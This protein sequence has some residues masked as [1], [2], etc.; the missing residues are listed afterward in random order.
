M[1]AAV[2]ADILSQK[3]DSCTTYSTQQ[4]VTC[5]SSE[6]QGGWTQVYNQFGF[7]D[8]T[9]DASCNPAFG[10]GNTFLP[11]ARSQYG[12]VQQPLSVMHISTP[13]CDVPF[14]PAAASS[15]LPDFSCSSHMQPLQQPALAHSVYTNHLFSPIRPADSRVGWNTLSPTFDAFGWT[16]QYAGGGQVR[17]Q[18][19]HR[20]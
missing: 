3:H 1:S 16:S 2:E 15:S 4:G 20:W 8:T 12:I 18:Q 10:F 19:H 9:H 17:H 6:A 5:A 7:L 14:Q 13:S 11:A